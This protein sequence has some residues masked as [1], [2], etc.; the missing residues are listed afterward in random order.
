MHAPDDT[1]TASRSE[2]VTGPAHPPARNLVGVWGQGRRQ[3]TP[4]AYPHLRALAAVR[5]IVGIFL[6]GLGAVML[7]HG[8]SGLAAVPLAGAALVLSIGYLDLAVARSAP[9]RA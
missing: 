8:D 6:V 9:P 4:W 1:T 3:I 2:Q 5:L 7:S